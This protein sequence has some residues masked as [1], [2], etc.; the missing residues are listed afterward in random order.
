MK[1][2]IEENGKFK[3]VEKINKD[4]AADFLMKSIVNNIPQAK[5]FEGKGFSYGYDYK[6][7]N[8]TFIVKYK[9]KERITFSIVLSV[10]MVYSTQWDLTY[11]DV[12][13][14]KS[15]P[16]KFGLYSSSFTGDNHTSAISKYMVASKGVW[17]YIARMMLTIHKNEK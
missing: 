3:L 15:G 4:E 6:G 10:D 2:L 8:F 14:K 11:Y 1:K 13:G 12:D 7:N 17:K 9:N 5:D 16:K